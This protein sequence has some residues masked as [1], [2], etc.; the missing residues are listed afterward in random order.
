MY[1]PRSLQRGMRPPFIHSRDPCLLS[2]DMGWHSSRSR[3]HGQKTS[4]LKAESR[5]KERK[6][7]LPC[8]DWLLGKESRSLRN[9]PPEHQALRLVR[10][11]KQMG[12]RALA[13]LFR[14]RPALLGRGMIS[15]PPASVH[16][17]FRS[18]PVP[19]MA[20]NLSVSLVIC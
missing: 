11:S 8:W 18:F 16:F 4:A 17:I 15:W 14:D 5:G 1:S 2:S 9:R 20:C 12:P 6:G 10:I 7:N 19:F 3:G 13:S